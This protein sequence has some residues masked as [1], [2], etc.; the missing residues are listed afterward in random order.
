[1]ELPLFPSQTSVR[2]LLSYPRQLLRQHLCPPSFLDYIFHLT[3]A[4][5]RKKHESVPEVMEKYQ[6]GDTL[7]KGNFSVVKVAVDKYTGKKYAA[8]IIDKKKILLQPILKEAFEREVDILKKVKHVRPPPRFPAPKRNSRV[9]LSASF[10]SLVSSPIMTTTKTPRTSTSSWICEH[11]F[12]VVFSKSSLL[13]EC[14]F[15]GH[16]RRTC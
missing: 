16:R 8:K 6:I 15:Q 11:S 13:D 1:L 10:S 3:G 9:H 5:T 2:C 4:N 14:S 7:G 12:V